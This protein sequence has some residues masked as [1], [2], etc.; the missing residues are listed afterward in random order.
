M[1]D[2]E[3]EVWRAVVGYEGLYEISSHGRLKRLAGFVWRKRK[4]VYDKI[5]HN[6][7]ILKNYAHPK[8]HL[9][10]ELYRQVNGT[11]VYESIQIHRLVAMAFIGNSPVGKNQVRH[12]NGIKDDNYYENL[13]WCNNSENQTK[14]RELG[15][16]EPNKKS[17]DCWQSKAVNRV[18]L[19]NG[20]RV[21]YGS[22]QEAER[23]TGVFSQNIIKVC[24]GKRNTA[25][26]FAWEYA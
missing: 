19:N 14:A 9:K 11:L 26:G 20:T 15:L 17:W 13:E 16:R 18:D 1:I 10:N 22:V 6:E 3:L 7:I 23:M 2:K 8:G 5:F 25:G 24:K 12:K 21:P 4:K